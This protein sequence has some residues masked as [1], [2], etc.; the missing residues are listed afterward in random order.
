MFDLN[1]F[2]WI[3][4]FV[5]AGWYWSDTSKA[6]EMAIAHGKRACKDMNL[7]FLDETVVRFRTTAKRGPEGQMRLAR[8]FSFEFTPDGIRRYPG[9]VRL[10]GNRLQMLDI[11]YEGTDP[12]KESNL[13][14]SAS[15][16][17]ETD[18]PQNVVRLHRSNSNNG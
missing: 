14:L 2:F 16:S 4:L 1:V 13:I 6:R 8:D 12:N 11:Q 18:Q 15:Y 5:L 3:F 17:K 9:H 10:L 7:Q